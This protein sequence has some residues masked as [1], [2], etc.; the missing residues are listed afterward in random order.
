MPRIQKE[1][2]NGNILFYV[3]WLAKYGDDNWGIAGIVWASD[4]TKF[5][6]LGGADRSTEILHS[7]EWQN[8]SLVWMKVQSLYGVKKSYKADSLV[9]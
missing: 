4:Q 1:S 2:K 8:I 3:M 5:S 7:L 9:E 6:C